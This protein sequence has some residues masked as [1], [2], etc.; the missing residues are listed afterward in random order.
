MLRPYQIAGRDFLAARKRA[1]LADQMRVGKTPQAIAAADLIGAR[2]VLVACPAIACE[3]WRNEWA[4]WSPGRPPAEIFT[5]TPPA[6]DYDGVAIMSYGR[7]VQHLAALN[8]ARPWD[9]VI[10]DEAHFA[11]NPDAQRTRAVYGTV[12]VGWNAERMWPLTGTPAPNH[13]G[14]LWPMLR[15]FGVVK[16]DYD[17]FVRYFCYI[18]DG[19]KVRGNKPSHIEELRALIQPIILRRTRKQVAPEMPEISYDFLAVAP[20]GVDLASENLDELTAENRIAV[21]MAK[22]PALVEEVRE[23]L[24]AGEYQQTVVFGY[25]V[26][27]LLALIRELKGQGIPAVALTG[28]TSDRN[29]HD[30]LAGFK[31]GAI[32]VIGAQILA[33]GTAVDMSAASHGYFLELDFVPGNN[34]QAANRLVSMQK[35]EPVTVDIVTW[36]GTTDDAVQRT[37]IRKVKTAVFNDRR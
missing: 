32:E 2:R 19:G 10:P 30:A 23:C 21:A 16:A 4:T 36:P 31:M 13:A 8:G 35:D 26:E 17:R 18:D 12:G 29:R 1:M 6:P 24:D 22:V 15:A 34:E 28:A 37:V 33:A 5:R 11:K 14:E 27:P 9:V 3:H 25:H 7:M 20:A